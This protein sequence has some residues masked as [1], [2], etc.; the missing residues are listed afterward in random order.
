MDPNEFRTLE[1]VVGW[2]LAR[3]L[4]I[5]VVPMDEFTNDVVVPV[6]GHT[7]LVFDSN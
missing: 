4:P 5:R 1:Q 3:D 7:V 6:D 2:A